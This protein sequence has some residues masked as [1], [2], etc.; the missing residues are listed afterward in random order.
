M[1]KNACHDARHQ[2]GGDAT[3]SIRQ[4]RGRVMA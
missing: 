1:G 2:Q 3:A 4:S